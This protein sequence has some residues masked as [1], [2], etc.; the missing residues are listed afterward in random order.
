MFL[1]PNTFFSGYDAIILG[2]HDFDAG[3]AGLLTMLNKARDQSLDV[4]IIAS[5]LVTLEEDSV[6]RAFVDNPQSTGIVPPYNL[7]CSRVFI[8]WLDLLTSVSR[9]ILQHHSRDNV[10]PSVSMNHDQVLQKI[11]SFDIASFS[12]DS[13]SHY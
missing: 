6:F 3:E 11:R 9:L 12:A 4:T 7:L 5:N 8:T 13:A 2:N 1:Y 10:V